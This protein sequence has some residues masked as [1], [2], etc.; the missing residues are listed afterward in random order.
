VTT[1]T[2]TKSAI[3]TKSASRCANLRSARF[4]CALGEYETPRS[5]QEFQRL[6]DRGFKLPVRID[7]S[8]VAGCSLALD[9]D[10][11]GF[12]IPR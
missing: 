11:A 6:F 8:K 5:Q 2:A 3:C 10:S 4:A 7:G 1:P 9:K 12:A